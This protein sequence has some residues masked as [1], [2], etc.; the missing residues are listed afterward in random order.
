MNPVHLQRLTR[1]YVVCGELDTKETTPDWTRVT[2]ENCVK[3]VDYDRL[4]RV[5]EVAR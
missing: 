1:R 3:R 2:C 5:N 4:R